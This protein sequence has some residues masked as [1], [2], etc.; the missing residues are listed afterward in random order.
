MASTSIGIVFVPDDIIENMLLRLPGKFVTQFRCVS[1]TWN[2]LISELM[3]N[4]KRIM[5]RV[6]NRN[7]SLVLTNVKY[8][9]QTQTCNVKYVW[10]SCDGL[11]CVTLKVTGCVVLWNPSTREYLAIWRYRSSDQRS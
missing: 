2:L 6:L 11:L 5:L 7:S 8:Q 3:E 9:S 4:K 1:K 10:G